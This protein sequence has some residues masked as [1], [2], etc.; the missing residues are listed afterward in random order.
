MVLDSTQDK[1]EIQSSVDPWE[2]PEFTQTATPWR[3]KYIDKIKA[4][5]QW[6]NMPNVSC[7]KLTSCNQCYV[8][9]AIRQK[10]IETCYYRYWKIFLTNWPHISIHMFVNTSQLSISIAWW[11]NCWRGVLFR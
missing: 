2:L 4:F 6:K 11:K 8:S 1:P 7:D 3:G 9:R 10:K 5:E